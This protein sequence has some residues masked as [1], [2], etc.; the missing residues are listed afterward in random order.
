MSPLTCLPQGRKSGMADQLGPRPADWTDR[1]EDAGYMLLYYHS[2]TGSHCSCKLISLLLQSSVQSCSGFTK[3]AG[4]YTFSCL[5]QEFQ[6]SIGMHWD[7]SYGKVGN[8]ETGRLFVQY[9]ATRTTAGHHLDIRTVRSWHPNL[10]LASIR[11]LLKYGIRTLTAIVSKHP[12]GQI[13]CVTDE[14][15]D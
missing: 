10:P 15:K 7:H 2:T 12:F 8:I 1:K 6:R 14:S 13:G 3:V 4:G 5:D 9:G 11:R